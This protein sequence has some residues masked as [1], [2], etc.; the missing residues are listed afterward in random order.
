[1]YVGLMMLGRQK[2]H[3]AKPPVPE[4]SDVL[5]EV[6]IENLKSPKSPSIDQTPAK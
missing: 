6:P 3:T 2:K 5:F 4:R 1:M